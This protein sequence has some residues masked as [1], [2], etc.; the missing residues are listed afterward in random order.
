MN[1]F[2]DQLRSD[3]KGKNPAYIRVKAIPKSS[4]NE[5]VEVMGDGTYKIRITA[6]A[7][8]NKANSTLIKFIKKGLGA[9]EISIISGQKDRIKLIKIISND[10]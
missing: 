1:N 9:D 5:I 7:E 8:K 3:I 6:A 10:Y 2:F 4:K